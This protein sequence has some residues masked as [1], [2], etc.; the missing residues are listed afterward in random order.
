M[1]GTPCNMPPLT[2]SEGPPCFSCVYHMYAERSGIIFISA[3]YYACMT[4]DLYVL[5]RHVH[6]Y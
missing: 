3:S 4:A 5:K 6:M 2:T 1:F